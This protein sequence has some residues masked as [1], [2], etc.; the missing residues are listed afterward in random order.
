MSPK[1]GFRHSEETKRK[2]RKPKS[3]VSCRKGKTFEDV[4]GVEK[5]KEWKGKIGRKS[6]GRCFSGKIRQKMKES[7]I[8]RYENPEERKKASKSQKKRF[9]NPEERKKASKIAK[10][11]QKRP[12]V[13]QKIRQKIIHRYENPE[14]RKKVG[15]TT[16]RYFETSANK[17][18][19]SMIQ[20]EIQNRPEVK[21]KKAESIKCYWE[22]PTNPKHRQQHERVKECKRIY[23]EL[24]KK[25]NG[26]CAICGGKGKIGCRLAVDHS[27]NSDKVR[28]L[29]CNSCNMGLGLFKDSLIVLKKA[30]EYLG[31]NN[32]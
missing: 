24:Y 10:E 17:E 13:K 9:E 15:V 23:D 2:M 4:V 20:K 8:H 12:E 29:L 26:V 16:K 31:R 7:A 22:N 6:R 28:G 30:V 27:H 18:K 3:G 19:H 11:V 32:T 5:A 21:Q 1:K 25:Q 14:E